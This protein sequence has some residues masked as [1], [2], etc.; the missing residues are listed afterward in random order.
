MNPAA[1]EAADQRR[2]AVA[3]TAPIVLEPPRLVDQ[4]MRFQLDRAPGQIALVALMVVAFAV[5]AIARFSAGSPAASVPPAGSAVAVASASPTPTPSPTPIVSG[6]PEPSASPS[7]P[8][9]RTTYKVKR[10]D[11]LSGIASRFKTTAA[12]IKALN[13]LKSNTLKVGQTLK[14]P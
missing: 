11:T 12:K 6:S 9:F 4:A 2:R 14:I 10:G 13:G 1:V 3:R 7:E 8:A 5:V